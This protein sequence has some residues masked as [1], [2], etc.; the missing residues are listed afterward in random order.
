MTNSSNEIFYCSEVVEC[1]HT[2]LCCRFCEDFEKCKDACD[3]QGD[4]DGQVS[5]EDIRLRQDRDMAELIVEMRE[6]EAHKVRVDELKENIDM[7]FR[8]LGETSYKDDR[9]SVTRTKDSSRTTVDSKKLKS[10]YPEIF[11]ACSK[12]SVTKGSLRVKLNG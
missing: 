5:M 12:T 6:L 2:G 8:M 11:E 10:E 9:I 4:C 7:Y 3:V 1:N